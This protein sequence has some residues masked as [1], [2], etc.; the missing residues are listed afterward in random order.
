MVISSESA[1]SESMQGEND[2]TS[3]AL[4]QKLDSEISG[5][6]SNAVEWQGGARKVRWTT[7]LFVW[8]VK[9]ML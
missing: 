2:A 1:V 5:I 3:L 8:L 4:R 9:G 7:K 6:R